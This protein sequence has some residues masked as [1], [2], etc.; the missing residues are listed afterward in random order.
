M[1]KNIIKIILIFQI[2]KIRNNNHINK[3][4]IHNNIDNIN[5][6]KKKNNNKN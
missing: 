2:K 4:T 1:K 6:N 3:N 5:N